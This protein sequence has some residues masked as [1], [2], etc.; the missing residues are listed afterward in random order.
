[1][2][3]LSVKMEV[4][5]AVSTFA[6]SFVTSFPSLS[7]VGS[8]CCGMQVRVPV[9]ALIAPCQIQLQPGFGLHVPACS[10]SVSV[11]FLGL[12]TLIPPCEVSFCI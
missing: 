11:F 2:L 6:M 7:A 10:D 1:M 9:E 4:K 5:K 8:C 12:L 3:I